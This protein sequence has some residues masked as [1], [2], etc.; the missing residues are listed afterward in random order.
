M[1]VHIKTND[2]FNYQGFKQMHT[3]FGHCI[4][5]EDIKITDWY[6][7]LEVKKYPANICFPWE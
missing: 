3:N 2:L 6:N 7:A 4:L 1:F 5:T